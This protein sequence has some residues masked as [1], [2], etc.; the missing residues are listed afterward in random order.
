[1]IHHPTLPLPDFALARVV[2]AGDVM[3]DRYWYGATSRISPEA[4]VPIVHVGASEERVG[5]AGNVAM[6]VT[7]L[8]GRAAVLG[9]VGD[10]D[11]GKRLTE[12]LEAGGCDV[13]CEQ[14]PGHATITKLRVISQHQ[15]LLRMDFE[16]RTDGVPTAALRQRLDDLLSDAGVLVLSDYAKGTLADPQPLIEAARARGIPVVVD[17][18]RQDFLAYRGA[19]LL[20][21]NL[22][23]FFQAV[24]ACPDEKTIVARG[25]DLL[26]ELDLQALLLTRG[27]DGMT[28]LR[29]DAAPLNL[30][31]HAREVFDVTGAGDTVVA[32]LAAAL[33]A[34]QDLEQAA[35]LA[36]TGAGIVVGK[37]GTATVSRAELERE[38]STR[39]TVP[40]GVVD[41]S[42]LLD[43]VQ[44]ARRRGETLVM[45]NGCFDLLHPGHVAYLEQAARLGDRLIVAVNDDASVQ[46]LK[47]APRPVNPLDHRMA[48]LAGL[49][50]V[51]WV[52]AFS[53]DT[54]ERLICAV[55]PDL[56]VK[57]GDY[58]P[59]QIA[60]APCVRAAGGEVRIIPLLPEHSTTGIIR[61]LQE[62]P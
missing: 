5:G 21:P 7:A 36:N 24:G 61:K 3:L 32:L 39:T 55:Q 51:D 16:Q 31:T 58:R 57:G 18:K 56:L 12:L 17:P 44:A 50:A 43:L 54:P 33:A 4:P 23:E 29:R 37:V 26:A 25:Q 9:Y 60:G 59:D 41:E 11:A 35:Y 19:T 45:T 1:M 34:G 42:Q 28:L 38:L 15:Q 46:R 49:R 27:E 13:A 62:G 48:V 10:D 52:V 53:E 47:G 2:I 8:G 30:P 14:L 40:H 20:T 22:K 6:N